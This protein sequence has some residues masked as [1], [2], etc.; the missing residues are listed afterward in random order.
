MDRAEAGAGED[1][2]AWE[3]AGRVTEPTWLA[4]REQLERG[5][6]VA[7]DLNASVSDWGLALCSVTFLGRQF[8]GL[9]LQAPGG[10]QVC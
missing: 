5:P 4:G 10:F 8:P 1:G 9:S 3:A 7:G 2:A 6:K